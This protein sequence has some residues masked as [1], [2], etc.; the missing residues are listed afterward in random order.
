M[1]DQWIQHDIDG[2]VDGGPEGFTYIPLSLPLRGPLAF[3][4]HR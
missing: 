1:T 3:L 4:S 2:S